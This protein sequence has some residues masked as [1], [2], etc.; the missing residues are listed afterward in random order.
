MNIEYEG[1]VTVIGNGGNQS[2][3]WNIS[4]TGILFVKMI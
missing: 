4:K 1:R 2:L 3:E